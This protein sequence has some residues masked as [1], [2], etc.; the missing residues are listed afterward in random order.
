[1]ASVVEIVNQA[2]AAL[3]EARITSLDDPGRNAGLAKSVY[4]T[5][6]DM[7]ISR[8]RWNFAKSRI[9][10]PALAAPP[11]FGWKYQYQLPADN[12]RVLEAGPWPQPVMS[13]YI[14]GNTRA[15]SVEGQYL[16][17]NL[18][19]P[20]SLLYLRR[21]EDPAF[22]PPLFVEA[23]A[24]RLAVKMCERVTGAQGKRQLAWQEYEQAIKLAKKTDYIQLPPQRPADGEW[25]AAHREAGNWPG[26]EA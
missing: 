6:R 14:A 7:E 3:G 13:D 17:S 15:W 9:M 20:L 10:L 18:A 26:P 2:F 4:N 21:I 12:L 11:V 25:M 16:V 23:L 1:M 24:A 22:Y 19:P 5:V 8:Y